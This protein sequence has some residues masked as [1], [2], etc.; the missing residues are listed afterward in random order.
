[1]TAGRSN[2]LGQ[3]RRI[4]ASFARA[5][6]YVIERKMLA[7]SAER[8]RTERV[9]Y[10]SRP[11]IKIAVY[12][13]QLSSRTVLSRRVGIVSCERR[14]SRASIFIS[15]SVPVLTHCGFQ[16]GATLVRSMMD[17]FSR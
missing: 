11:E 4:V 17:I 3:G 5:V 15:V 13:M 16:S 1:M 14:P 2:P 12:L 8:S 9:C 10:L 7:V 6:I